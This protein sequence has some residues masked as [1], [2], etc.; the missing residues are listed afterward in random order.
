[1]TKPKTKVQT[2]TLTDVAA[3][4]ATLTERVQAYV[5][6]DRDV[7]NATDR[8]ERERAMSRRRHATTRLR[9]L[10][11]ETVA[12]LEEGV[13]LSGGYRAALTDARKALGA[14]G[15]PLVDGLPVATA[16]EWDPVAVYRC[17][18]CSHVGVAVDDFG[19]R[20]D[21]MRVAVADVATLRATW[22]D[23]EHGLAPRQTRRIACD[24]ARPHPTDPAACYVLRPYRQSNCNA[25]RT[26]AARKRAE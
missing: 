9:S 23:P 3:F 24:V 1:M 19:A 15:A 4:R 21:P 7:D 20:L 10:V 17:P 22:L 13:T 12:T 18:A 5:N 25:C 14:K 26:L 8:A 6:A 16:R 2:E 11:S